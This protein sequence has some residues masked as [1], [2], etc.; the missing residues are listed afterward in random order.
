MVKYHTQQEHRGRITFFAGMAMLLTIAVLVGGGC[1]APTLRTPTQEARQPFSARRESWDGAIVAWSGYT[2]GYEPGME[3][4]FDITIKN[5]TEEAW[6][7]RYCLQLLDPR[8]SQVV[9]TLEQ[10]EFSLERGV[11]F[12]DTIDVQFPQALEDGV[13]GLSLAVRRSGGPMVDLVPIRVGE[14]DEP[15]R[16]T[17]LRALDAALEA[18]P[19]VQ[20]AELE[21]EPLVEMAKAKLIDHLGVAPQKIEVQ[22]VVEARFPDASLGVPEAGKSYAQVITPGYVI[23]MA[24]NDQI[25]TYHAASDRVVLVPRN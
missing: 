5:E 12:S 4:E 2:E 11:G 19:P 10:R 13:Y 14:T 20:G 8:F 22:S 7:G 18:C 9:A 24:V 17:T 15:R 1:A 3:A 23:E 6:Q 25:Y 21:A 16:A